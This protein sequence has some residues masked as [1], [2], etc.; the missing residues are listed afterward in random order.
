M[1]F[2][3]NTS[4]SARIREHTHILSLQYNG[5]YGGFLQSY[6]LQKAVS[7]VQQAECRISVLD[8]RYLP[9]APEHSLRALA[10]VA[11][12]L[13]RLKFAEA[14]RKYGSWLSFRHMRS[15]YRKVASAA[16]WDDPAAPGAGAPGQRY[17]VGSDQVWRVEYVHYGKRIP[18]YFLDFAPE[19][20]RKRSIAYAASFGSDT[21]AATPEQREE[22]AA[23]LRQFKAVS[24]REQ[25]AVGMCRELFGVEAVQMPDPTLLSGCEDYNKLIASERTSRPKGGYIASYVLDESEGSR[26]AQSEVSRSLGLPLQ[27]MAALSGSRR[28][29]RIRLS[30]PQWLRYLRDADYILTD[31][32]HGCI[33]AMIFNRPFVC[34]GNA[35]RGSSRFD[36]LFSTFQPESRMA[37]SPAEALEVLRRPVDWDA[38]NAILA[39]ERERGMQFLRDNL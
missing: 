32:F 15:F 13:L 16:V 8:P 23:A 24:V 27:H 9:S 28:R 6:A 18:F 2:D 19:S 35:H 3:N 33:F 29:P 10:G 38:V 25:S 36:T 14:R 34:L 26:R 37:A 30:V 22:C 17:I 11:G 31:S 21:W 12:A 20:V 4:E 39:K 1:E 5:N 7:S